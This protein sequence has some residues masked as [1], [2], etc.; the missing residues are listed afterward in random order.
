MQLIALSFPSTAATLTKRKNESKASAESFLA[1]LSLQ[2]ELEVTELKEG[3]FG[4]VLPED[5]E[6]AVIS[7]AAKFGAKIIPYQEAEQ[8]QIQEGTW[9]SLKDR[10]AGVRFSMRGTEATEPVEG[11]IKPGKYF[12]LGI[13]ESNGGTYATLGRVDK[14]SEIGRSGGPGKFVYNVDLQVL[15]SALD[16]EAKVET[17]KPAKNES[18]VPQDR[19]LEILDMLLE[20][21]P[22]V[23]AEARR[24]GSNT[25]EADVTLDELLNISD[26][27]AGGDQIQESK[28]L[29][30]SADKAEKEPLDEG[31]DPDVFLESRAIVSAMEAAGYDLDAM[32]DKEFDEAVEKFLS[33]VEAEGATETAEEK[34]EE[35]SEEKSEETAEAEDDQKDEAFE[36]A[37][38][39][40]DDKKED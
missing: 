3:V 17:S 19:S 15:A 9:I 22:L 24:S 26:A 13:E 29:Q 14:L 39:A 40:S 6:D 34:S 16:T 37:T 35:Q 31:M 32:S 25:Q 23:L 18:T 38:P 12:V 21:D 7:R 11:D 1:E 30:E 2:G 4:C 36:A 33:E 27:P 10:A 5:V 28:S 20:N 8:P